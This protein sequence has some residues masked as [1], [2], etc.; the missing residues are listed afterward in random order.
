M[1]ASSDCCNRKREPQPIFTSHPSHCGEPDTEVKR[2]MTLSLCQRHVRT[3]TN[4]QLVLY[5]TCYKCR[6][7]QGRP[8]RGTEPTDLSVPYK[9]FAPRVHFVRN[10]GVE[11]TDV[12]RSG[13]PHVVVPTQQ[14]A[15]I[16]PWRRAAPRARRSFHRWRRARCVRRNPIRSPGM[17]AGIRF[18]D[19]SVSPRRWAQPC[20]LESKAN[21]RL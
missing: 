5:K 8:S 16:P 18:G 2:P 12:D 21:F 13:C 9:S 3:E 20:P 6:V 4:A 19:H 7:S 1:A 10:E 14:S 11:F 17:L 15:V